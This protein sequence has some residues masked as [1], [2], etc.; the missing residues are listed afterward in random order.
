MTISK[1]LG[2]VQPQDAGVHRME[3]AV[4]VGQSSARMSSSKVIHKGM[5]LSIRIPQ[6]TPFSMQC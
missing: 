4:T 1:I 5:V 3:S 6:E 2:T